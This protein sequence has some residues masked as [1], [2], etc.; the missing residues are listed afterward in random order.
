MKPA[1]GDSLCY[2]FERNGNGAPNA[3]RHLFP[4]RHLSAFPPRAPS[5]FRPMLA[6]CKHRGH[7]GRV[8]YTS[9]LNPF[10]L[11]FKTDIKRR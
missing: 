8:K 4:P 5:P 1:F 3:P 7:I 11:R 9:L 6:R 2:I 10:Y